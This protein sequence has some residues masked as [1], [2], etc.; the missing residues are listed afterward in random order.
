MIR[1]PT[2][3]PFDPPRR[4]WIPQALVAPGPFR[5]GFARA[6]MVLADFLLQRFFSS[7]GDLSH[8]RYAVAVTHQSI[9]QPVLKVGLVHWVFAVG[10]HLDDCP[11][12]PMAHRLVCAS[13]ELQLE[14]VE[15]SGIINRED[16]DSS[17]ARLVFDPL[18]PRFVAE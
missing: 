12:R 2:P 4:V 9:F 1:L 15:I 6:T 18:L 14:N 3:D 5:L 11:E 8:G 17:N 10:H 16:I 7:A 13:V